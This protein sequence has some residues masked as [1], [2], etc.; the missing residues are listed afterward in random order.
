MQ[1]TLEASAPQARG[2]VLDWLASQQQA[3][4]DLLQKVVNIDSGSRDEA[5]VT[6]VAHAL[7]E[8]LQAAGVPVQFEA[9]PGYGVLLHA[10]VNA[11]GEGA[12]IVLM[13]RTWTRYSPPVRSPSDLT[14]RKPG[15]PT[16]LAWPT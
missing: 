8:R 7:A 13:G 15:A 16:A 9:V 10:Q 6:A 11:A 2:L 14:A 1:D 4:Q 5:G 12:P 3:M